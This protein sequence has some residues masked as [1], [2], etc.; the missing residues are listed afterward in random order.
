VSVCIEEKGSG[1]SDLGEEIS[2]C[3]AFWGVMK[4][5]VDPSGL[6]MEEGATRFCLFFAGEKGLEAEDVSVLTARDLGT[7]DIGISDLATTERGGVEGG[8]SEMSEC[9]LVA[10][11]SL[12]SFL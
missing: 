3:A 9:D 10:F 11:P 4:G 12:E 7:I 2:F 8:G 6:E 5:L 1:D